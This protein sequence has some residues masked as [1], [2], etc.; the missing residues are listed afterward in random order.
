MISSNDFEIRLC[1]AIFCV[2]LV[3]CRSCE[4]DYSEV[5]ETDTCERE[6]ESVI[7][8]LDETVDPCE[9]FYRFACGGFI[10]STVIPDDKSTMEVFTELDDILKK[11]LND[12]L[13]STVT[14]DDIEP[15]A[16]SKRFFKACLNE[17]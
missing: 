6:S 9:D 12:I 10:K 13:N 11:E 17:G 7:A 14:S 2:N 15:I 3:R 16:N 1:V 4:T 8:K 5:C